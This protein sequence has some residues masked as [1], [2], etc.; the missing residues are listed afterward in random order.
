MVNRKRSAGA[1][2]LPPTSRC[3]REGPR[4]RPPVGRCHRRDADQALLRWPEADRGRVCRRP[5]KLTLWRHAI[6]QHQTPRCSAVDRA[7]RRRRAA[8]DVGAR[9]L[10]GR[11][12]PP[13]APVSR[14]PAPAARRGRRG[15][16]TIVLAASPAPRARPQRPGATPARPAWAPTGG[17]AGWTAVCCTWCTSRHVQRLRPW[18]SGTRGT[19]PDGERIA[20]QQDIRVASIVSTSSAI[21]R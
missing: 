6:G 1:C 12:A 21:P 10:G 17:T 13:P 7:Q 11:L 9:G 4:L 3:Y 16:S 19:V 18:P 2:H 14:L 15:T 8:R 20:A 5:F